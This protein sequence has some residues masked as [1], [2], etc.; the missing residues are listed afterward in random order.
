M[1]RARTSHGFTA[2]RIEGG[3]LPPEFLQVVA[4]LQAPHQDAPDYGLSKSLALKEE[5]A[6]YWRIAS[7]LHASLAER[8]SRSDLSA[9][10]VF[11]DEWLVPLL[12]EVMG[13]SDLSPCMPVELGDRFFRLSHLTLDNA[14]PCLLTH[15]RHHLDR[16]GRAFAEDGRRQAPH[17]VM[18][19]YLNADDACLWGIVSNGSKLRLLR[20]NA[21][22]TRPAYIEAD[23]D[24]IFAEQLY[25]DFA[26]LWL[27]GHASRLATTD[28]KPSSCIAEGWRAEAIER[29]ERVLGHLRDGVA[30]ALL[31]LGNGFLSHPENQTIRAAL[32]EG[33][34]SR[35]DYFQQLL[36][37]VYR[38]LFLF[39][40]EE[41]G[42][43]FAPD[44]AQ[45]QR[46]MY[47]DGYSI[48]RLRDRALRRRHYDRHQDLWQGLTITFAALGAGAPGLGLPPLGGLF[49]PDQCPDL[50][51]AVIAN[52]D[53]LDA[54]RSL[55]FFRT[56][57]TLARVNYRDMG[58]EELGSVYESLL[59]LQPVLDV[60]AEPWT[61]RFAG[62]GAGGSER[63]LTGSYYTPPPLVN[64]LVK[65]ALDPVLADAIARHPENPRKAILDLRVV[66]PA[67][68]SGHFLLAAARRMAA[69]VA[70]IDAA[71]HAPDEATRQHALRDVVRHCVHGVDR[72]PLAVELCRTALWIETVEPGKPLTFLDAHIQL[73]DSL[74]GVLHP[75][76][77]ANGIPPDAYKPLTGDD[78]TAC[79]ALRQRNKDASAGGQARLF[80]D[81]TV[82]EVAIIGADLDAMPED[83]LDDVERKSA[84]WRAALE[85]DT[86]AKEELRADLFVGAFFADKSKDAALSV[87]FSDDLDRVSAGMAREAVVANVR[88]LAARHRFFH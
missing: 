55:A 12:R 24:L 8:R 30:E 31:Q 32:R 80:D 43:L 16:A 63:K 26:A 78:K 87:P 25:P 46:Q 49:R 22:M 52:E 29:G 21:S 1:A 70:R 34:L 23:L 54:V 18:Q 39:A 4:G 15:D 42:L 10:R 17:A 66:D 82:L 50:D 47:A 88:E 69:E 65:S 40:T 71:P 53:L 57:S 14:V 64:E 60:Q 51:S 83:T 3:I 38:I 13:Y 76:V 36:R 81:E 27:A 62:V 6:R 67:C 2:L 19:E 33:V 79:Q 35:D 7:D 45:E 5:L 20:D 44:A 11:V 68:G 9:H 28:G 59:E 73:G 77:M 37:L 85:E 86:R 41:R 61:F 56:D 75:A 48:S 74:I 72:N 58:T 84:A